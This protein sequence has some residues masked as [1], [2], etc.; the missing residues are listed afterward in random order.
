MEN[1]TNELFED[2]TAEVLMNEA[3]Y[4]DAVVSFEAGL[5]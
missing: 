5:L 3:D 2:D 1:E 4:L